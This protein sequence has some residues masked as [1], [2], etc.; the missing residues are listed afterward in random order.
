[1]TLDDVHRLQRYWAKFPPV[2]YL[3][4]GFVSFEIPKTFGDAE[5][6]GTPKYMTAEDLKHMMAMTGGRVPGMS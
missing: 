1:M 2:R 5:D 6:D 3:V 4:A